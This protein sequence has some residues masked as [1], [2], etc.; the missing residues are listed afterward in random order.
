M[1]PGGVALGMRVEGQLQWCG[2]S[3]RPRYDLAE[4]QEAAQWIRNL[5]R[6]FDRASV[7]K[8]LEISLE[9][10]QEVL[11]HSWESQRPS[12]LLKH[13][14]VIWDRALHFLVRDPSGDMWAELVY[15]GR[16]R[17]ELSVQLLP[18]SQEAA[19]SLAPVEMTWPMDLGNGQSASV[20]AEVTLTGLVPV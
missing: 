14:A 17:K 20:F 2:S 18:K 15:K 5:C 13:E 4:T 3:E 19:T 16:V 7:A 8:C 12:Q 9:Q 11:S 1:W 10:I 6:Q